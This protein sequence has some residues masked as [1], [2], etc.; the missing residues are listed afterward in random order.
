MTTL[1]MLMARPAVATSIVVACI[2]AGG[3]ASAQDSG[4]RD[5]AVYC[6]T[7]HGARGKGNG[8]AVDVIPGFKP[9]DL[10]ELA[11]NHAG[12]F[13]AD[14]VRDVIDGRKQLPGHR[15]SDTDMPLWGVTFQEEGK[16][17]TPES[18]A[19]VKRRIAALVEYIRSMQQK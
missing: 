12:A 3:I 19:K 16:E 8:P 13:P 15:D 2:V 6:A 11:K 4:A 10:T 17:F 1:I 14:E 5:Y 7:C 18:E 9:V